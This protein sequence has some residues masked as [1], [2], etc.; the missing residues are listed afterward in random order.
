ML[1]AIERIL[2][3]N[4]NA[5]GLN[6][7]RILI[8][9]P[10]HTAANVITQRLGA[11]LAPQH[12]FRLLDASRPTSTI[13]M[14]LSPFCRLDENTGSFMLP[15]LAELFTFDVIVSTCSDCHL[16]YRAGFTNQQLR[17]Q[18]LN[19]AQNACGQLQACG[20]HASLDMFPPIMNPHFTHLFID[21]AA[22]ATEAES[23][24]ALS[25]VADPVG[26]GVR[27][28]DVALIGDPRQLS[29]RVFCTR[30]AEAGL[31]RSWMERLL[32]QRS[33][34]TGGGSQTLLGPDM[35]LMESLL[36]F[37]LQSQ[38]SLSLSHFLT[39]NYRGHP[40]FLALPSALF[41]SDLLQCAPPVVADAAAV[42]TNP[43]GVAKLQPREWLEKL[44]IVESLSSPL[45]PQM[46]DGG[47]DEVVLDEVLVPR[48]HYEFPIHFRGVIGKD[49]SVTVT[50]GF[51]ADSW[52][53]REEA[54][55][56]VEIIKSLL[57]KEGGVA[58]DP[59]SIGVMAPFRGQVD[60]IRKL[61]RQQGFSS[62]DVGT[63]E[64]Y[65]A[66]ECDVVVLSLTRSLEA[67]IK[68]DIDRRLGVFGQPKRSNVA[69]T[70]AENMFIVVGNPN[71]MMKHFI[72]RQFLMFCF[73]NGLHYGEKNDTFSCHSQG[74]VATNNLLDLAAS[75]KERPSL[76]DES[77]HTHEPTPPSQTNFDGVIVSSL[78]R[79]LRS[80]NTL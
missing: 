39:V 44:R 64:D 78:E 16:L 19:I 20:V 43:G 31:G 63:I 14:A 51:S 42:P 33:D 25:V 17:T 67:L 9:S 65:Q 49:V 53:N 26:S 30:A 13:P 74:A 40:A 21:E 66:K 22:Q 76:Q 50:S 77:E 28:V 27:K 29:P 46:D 34:C 62:V 35:N 57:S 11:I 2:E 59:R 47:G 37:S 48:K 70:R 69:M 38:N 7:L 24:V 41:Y 23:L 60:L 45:V 58:V 36:R 72:W 54:N 75:I 5:T 10:S 56:V 32:R 52:Q 15:T 80:S 12:L 1:A 79:L 6:R 71:T 3:L 4:A 73:R 18:R 68:H 55:A 61:L 8:C